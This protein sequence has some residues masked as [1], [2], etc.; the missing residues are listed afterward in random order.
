MQM[1]KSNWRKSSTLVIIILFFTIGTNN[2]IAQQ[3][4]HNELG[5]SCNYLSME[6]LPILL[7]SQLFIEN[8]EVKSILINV[9]KNIIINGPLSQEE[10]Q[11]LVGRTRSV[12]ANTFAKISTTD[13]TDG[14]CYYFPGLLRTLIGWE[15][16]AKGLII[17]YSPL[18]DF[19]QYGWHLTINNEE[20]TK[21]PGVI[22]GYFGDWSI[23][24]CSAP[25]YFSPGMEL[26]GSALLII[27][28]L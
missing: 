3:I 19:E 4:S 6:H 27:H 11:V 9:V 16:T 5:I 10:V 8:I 28:G 20:V 14:N 15:F 24:F 7:L 21:E 23:W 18:H 22:I 2:L 26:N 17:T 25:P 12:R 13:K 1:K